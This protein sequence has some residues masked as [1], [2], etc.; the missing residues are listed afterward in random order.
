MYDYLKFEGILIEII[1]DDKGFWISGL[2][3]CEC[4]GFKNPDER[5]SEIYALHE[6]EFKP[7]MSCITDVETD[8]GTRQV[9]V[10]SP[11]GAW[12]FAW[13]AAR[14]KK[15][16]A[17]R[18]W[19]NDTLEKRVAD[20]KRA[21]KQAAQPGLSQEDVEDMLIEIRDNMLWIARAI[22]L[23]HDLFTRRIALGKSDP[24]RAADLAQRHDALYEEMSVRLK[25]NSQMLRQI[26]GEDMKKDYADASADIQFLLNHA[27]SV[28]H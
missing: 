17:F 13:F 24:E 27:G 11:F 8:A 6:D 2:T 18:K 7:F 15:T 16:F 22:D 25:R 26:L 28:M 23:Y 3:I 12:V 20:L 1:R 21:E 10:F 14:R 19:L 4:L 9:R 5:L